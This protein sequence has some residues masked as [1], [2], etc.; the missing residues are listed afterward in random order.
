MVHKIRN[1]DL[2]PCL[3]ALKEA[4]EREGQNWTGKNLFPNVLMKIK[5][6]PFVFTNY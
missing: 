6:A 4:K 3:K 5:V 2:R 1:S